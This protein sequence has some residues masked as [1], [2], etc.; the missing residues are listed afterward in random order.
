MN[1]TFY[2]TVR[3]RFADWNYNHPRIIHGFILALK[4]AVIVEVGLYRGFSACWMAQ[5]LQENNTGKLYA[6]DNFSLREHVDRYGDPR[7]HVE[8]NLRA[9]GIDGWVQINEG[10]SS[11]PTMWPDRVDFCYIDGWHSYLQAKSDM[12]MAVERGATFIAFDDTENCVGPRMLTENIRKGGMLSD[13]WDFIDI[14]S[15]NGLFI[16]MKRQ[17]KR[18]VTFS[19]ELP[20]P[21]PGVDIR[22]LSLDQQAEHFAEASAITKVDYGPLLRSTEHDLIP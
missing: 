6:I 7:A 14:H 3:T 1:D 17:P 5:A 20:L 12:M 13:E 15:D 16:M 4:P 10:E 22:P 8:E 21:N 18:P 2:S 11:D 19:Q 9:C